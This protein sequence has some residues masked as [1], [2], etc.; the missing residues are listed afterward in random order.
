MQGDALPSVPCTSGASQ[1]TVHLDVVIQLEKCV[2]V[3]P[4]VAV[5]LCPWV[6]LTD[7]REV[8]AD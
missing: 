7:E 6:K 3:Y 8:N 2:P 4:L 5:L 1:Q